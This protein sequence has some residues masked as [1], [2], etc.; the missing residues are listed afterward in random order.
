MFG[1]WSW[2]G[3]QSELLK[4]FYRVFLFTS[5]QLFQNIIF[6]QCVGD[7]CLLPVYYSVMFVCMC[8]RVFNAFEG[9]WK[10][11]MRPEFRLV[12]VWEKVGD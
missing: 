5:R 7:L 10:D 9:Y 1:N 2:L 3:V 6:M 4:V 12:H 8:S 11:Q